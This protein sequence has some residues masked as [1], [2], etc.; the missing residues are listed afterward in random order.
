MIGETITIDYYDQGDSFKEFLPRDGK[1]LKLLSNTESSRGWFLVELKDPFTFG[2]SNEYGNPTLLNKHILIK[3]R[4]PVEQDPDGHAYLAL[5]LEPSQIEKDVIDDN[6]VLPVC[7]V[8]IKKKSCNN[9]FLHSAEGTCK[10]LPL[11][12]CEIGLE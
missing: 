2:M 10:T 8:L 9:T 11:I 12:C 4:T 1:V 3:Y 7:W 5:I 6:I